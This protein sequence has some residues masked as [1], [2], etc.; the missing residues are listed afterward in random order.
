MTSNKVVFVGN[1]HTGKTHALHR[2]LSQPLP[3]TYAPTVGASV[4]E[5]ANNYEIWDTA[6][7]KENAGLRDGYYVGTKAFVI[8][9]PIGDWYKD[10]SR[11]CPDAR[12]HFY[13]N[14]A[15]LKRFIY[16]L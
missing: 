12:I 3:K 9:G 1:A 4:V 14:P 6:G 10:V 2:L 5:F 16:D 15:S 7:A 8:F 13:R 11:I